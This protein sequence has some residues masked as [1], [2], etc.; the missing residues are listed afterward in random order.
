MFVFFSLETACKIAN[1]RNMSAGEVDIFSSSLIEVLQDI[2]NDIGNAGRAIT[3]NALNLMHDSVEKIPLRWLTI[4]YIYYCL[5]LNEM[6]MRFGYLCVYMLNAILTSTTTS[7]TAA[8]TTTIIIFVF[9]TLKNCDCRC[10]C[11]YYYYCY[12]PLLL[13][14]VLLLLL[15]LTTTTT[16]T[17]SYLIHYQSC[18]ISGVIVVWWLRVLWL[19]LLNKI[20]FDL[21]N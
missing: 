2:S 16:S 5:T 11:Y 18:N 7:S 13:L 4:L 10:C 15:L 19:C 6:L 14:L 9:V 21:C 20:M 3:S 17:R 12:L 8:T 1:K